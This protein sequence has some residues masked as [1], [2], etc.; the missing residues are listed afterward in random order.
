MTKSEMDSKVMSS[1]GQIAV[2]QNR[3][4]VRL[5]KDTVWLTQKQMAELFDKDVRTINEHILNIFKTKELSKISVIRN[6]RITA[7]DGKSYKTQMYDLDMIIS[8]G[9]RVNS[10]RGTQF[11]IWATNVLRKHLV[12]GF[13]LN[14]KRLKSAEHKYQ[15]LQKSI[16]LL[17]N[18][19]QLEGVSDEAKG[20]AQVISDYSRALD[21]LDDFDHERLSLPKGTKKAKYKLTYDKAKAIIEQMRQKF[22][23]SK[24]VGQEKD[25]SFKSS[26]GAIYQTFDGRDLYP[27]IE[28][29]AVMV[30]VIANLLA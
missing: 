17:G 15:E 19:A 4:E 23:D 28:E 7:S 21:L 27:T 8:V 6:F 1:T 30:K 20:I 10:L 24:L 14:E 25:Q 5:E 18:I 9:Y 22:K 29:K 13:T 16:K 2:Y 11:R 12:D 26:L 3:V